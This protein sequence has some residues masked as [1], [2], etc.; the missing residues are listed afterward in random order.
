MRSSNRVPRRRRRSVFLTGLLAAA[1]LAVL[2]PGAQADTVH[3]GEVITT[4]TTVANNLSGCAGDGIVIGAGGI[5]VDLGGH[6]IA[7][8]GLGTG[9]RNNGHA[10]V[11]I[12]NGSVKQFDYGIVL[13]PGTVRNTVTGVAVLETEWSG[14]HLDGA[15]GNQVT[16]SH[17]S[18]FS[19]HGMHVLGGS[20][21]N[22][23]ASNTV[24]NGNGE[25]FVVEGG[26]NQNRIEGNVVGASSDNAVRVD[27][28][29]QN[30]L[31]GNRISG[32][33][34]L[35]IT[36]T[37]SPGSVVQSNV[38]TGVGDAGIL[39]AESNRN[40]VRFNELGRSA[41]AGIVL[42]AVSDSLVKANTMS[43]AGDAGVV[44]RHESNGNRVID[45]EAHH[46]SDAGVFVGDGVWNVV[47]GNTLLGNTIGI[48][49]SGGNTNIVEFN[50][51]NQSLGAGIE[52]ASSTQARLFGNTTNHNKGGGIW[53][54]EAS[55]SDIKGNEATGNGGDGLTVGG[56]GAVVASNLA[57]QNQ[58]WGIY[59]AAGV[60]DGGGNG[61][62]GN[63]EA[64]QCYLIRCS[65]G[66]D[67]VKPVRPPE[68]LDPLEIG[69]EGPVQAPQ[70]RSLRRKPKKK[71]RVAV[72]TC[73]RPRPVAAGRKARR[74]AARKAKRTCRLSYRARGGSRRVTG[75]LI[76]DDAFV[77]RGASKV[78]SGRRGVLALRARKHLRTGRYLLVLTFEDARGRPTVVRKN[79]RVR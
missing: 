42:D 59:A 40:V 18:G 50:V 52:L 28:S 78:R 36:M 62:R 67:W 31:I 5:T 4:S 56:A 6:T 61:A 73:K 25:S 45:N 24:G 57:V 37:K 10:D 71:G 47:R 39:M 49:V 74:K 72:V 11:T 1:S 17:V 44:L 46:S 20:S 77:A 65:D 29:A 69:L 60:V 9:V 32:G 22:L 33:S 8:V 64:A 55:G 26:S 35:A 43:H 75:R 53:A 38:V 23:L 41:D 76:H 48:E 51:A 34:D 2:A 7:G 63:A 21:G 30:F 12:R 27:G 68:P 15:S 66:S 16:H 54:E 79:V 3:C 58:G 19:D 13:G 70:V 14:V